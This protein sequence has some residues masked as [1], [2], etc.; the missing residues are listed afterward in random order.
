MTSL[1][2][3]WGGVWLHFQR[4]G[5]WVCSCVQNTGIGKGVLYIKFLHQCQ[6]VKVL[7]GHCTA[8]S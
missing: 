1:L 6:K 8:V 5:V 7:Q 3:G 2:E 4:G